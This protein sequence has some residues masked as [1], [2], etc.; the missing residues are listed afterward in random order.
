MDDLQNQIFE[1]NL[2]NEPYKIIYKVKNKN[3]KYHYFIYIFVGNVPQN[4]KKNLIKIQNLSLTD[5][6]KN[7]NRTEFNEL[8]DYYGDKWFYYFFNKYHINKFLN[9]P[10]TVINEYEKKFNIKFNIRKLNFIHKF[11]YGFHVER[12]NTIH[13]KLVRKIL[14]ENISDVVK[15]QILKEDKEDIN[16]IMI[17]G[18]EENNE[19]IEDDFNS[20][21]NAKEEI[22]NNEFVEDEEENKQQEENNNDEV[23]EEIEDTQAN[24]NNVKIEMKNNKDVDEIISKKDIKNTLNF[25]EFDKSKD[26]DFYDDELFKCYKKLYI[27]NQYI[28]DSDTIREIK[29]KIFFS[30]KNNNIYG[31]NNFLEPSRV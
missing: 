21:L 1:K 10:N 26:N 12:K 15:D 2:L 14:K 4:I 25:I 23:D 27:F 18:Q 17:G 30:I 28:K 19:E 29:E 13:N 3:N 7:L 20:F 31:S 8:K 16:D 22:N 6:F 5:A 11:T 24:I 9:S